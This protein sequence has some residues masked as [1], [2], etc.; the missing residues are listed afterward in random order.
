MLAVA[1][2]CRGHNLYLVNSKHLY[3]SG[4]WQSPNPDTTPVVRND[5]SLANPHDDHL[6]GNLGNSR[7]APAKRRNSILADG[8]A[9]CHAGCSVL[10]TTKDQYSTTWSSCNNSCIADYTNRVTSIPSA[11]MWQIIR[12]LTAS[13][14]RSSCRSPDPGAAAIALSTCCVISCPTSVIA[15]GPTPQIYLEYLPTPIQNPKSHAI[16]TT[17]VQTWSTDTNLRKRQWQ[18]PLQAEFTPWSKVCGD[19]SIHWFGP[20][21]VPRLVFATPKL[22]NLYMSN[23]QPFMTVRDFGM[24][25]CA[26]LRIVKVFAETLRSQTVVRC[27][28]T[29]M[30]QNNLW[31]IPF[32]A[33]TP[34]I[35]KHIW[36]SYGPYGVLEGQTSTRFKYKSIMENPTIFIPAQ[37]LQ[38]SFIIFTAENTLQSIWIS[39]ISM[40]QMISI[41]F[42]M[43][44]KLKVVYPVWIQRTYCRELLTHH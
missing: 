35:L 4:P 32:T 17:P 3:Q 39:L 8:I 30:Q 11:A 31:S 12:T 2:E 41:V 24:A 29:A 13:P 19:P 28:F 25:G 15:I 38:R 42:L 27:C 34:E 22:L 44:S 20:S 40:W 43:H 6:C 1:S 16:I 7:H 33:H 36:Y 18:C 9:S 23:R 21:D 5:Q 10:T 26:T 37:S 14:G